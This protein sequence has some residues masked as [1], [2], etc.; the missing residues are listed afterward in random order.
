V[1]VQR[2]WATALLDADGHVAAHSGVTA[3]PTVVVIGRIPGRAIGRRPWVEAEGRA[4]PGELQG[5][6]GGPP[7]RCCGARM[8]SRGAAPHIRPGGL[9]C[10]GP[11]PDLP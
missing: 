10:C 5:G 6:V 11:P 4:L 3:T 7:L 9:P 8:P 2:Y 1:A